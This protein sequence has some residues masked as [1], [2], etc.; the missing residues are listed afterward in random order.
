MVKTE[1]FARE[2]R[3]GDRFAASGPVVTGIYELDDSY[4][5]LLGKEEMTVA[6]STKLAIWR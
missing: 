3:K 2:L 5:L 4:F 6:K 1:I